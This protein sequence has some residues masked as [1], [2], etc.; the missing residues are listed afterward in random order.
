MSPLDVVRPN[1]RPTLSCRDTCCDWS[2]GHLSTTPLQHP[3]A[4][5]TGGCTSSSCYYSKDESLCGAIHVL[6]KSGA[7]GGRG[8][9]AALRRHPRARHPASVYP[10]LLPLLAARRR[11]GL[12]SSGALL[13]KSLTF[14]AGVGSRGHAHDRY[15]E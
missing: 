8:S 9:P 5:Q 3:G 10:R 1:A 12:L 2:G 14:G 7:S 4:G 11:L 15:A 6:L 13:G